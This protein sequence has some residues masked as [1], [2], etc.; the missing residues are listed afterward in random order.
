MS[1]QS[2]HTLDKDDLAWVERWWRAT[3]YVAAAQIFLKDNVLLREPLEA[4]HIKPRL[5]GH[6]G[7]SPG[8]NLLYTHLLRAAREH[9]LH[10][11]FVAGPGHGAPAVLA[12]VWLEGS[13]AEVEPSLER[14]ALGLHRLCRQFSTPGGVSSHVGPHM[15]GSLHEGGELG[16]GLLHAFGAVFDHPELLALAVVGDGEAETG[17]ASGAWKS[18]HYLNPGRDGAVLPVLHLNGWRIAAPT[19][20]G[21]MDDAALV[22]HFEG[23]GYRVLVVAGEEPQ[24]VHQALAS[25]M[26]S[27]MADIKAIQARW[28]GQQ[29]AHECTP[30]WPM[31][32][33]RTPKGWTGPKQVDGHPVE[34]SFRSHQVPLTRAR[35]D[36]KQ[37]QQLA[38]WLTSYR[39]KELFD[40]HGRPRPELLQG[41]P[42]ASYLPGR[43]AAANGGRRRVDLNLPALD[44]AAVRVDGPGQVDAES[45]RALGVWL[46]ELLV[47]NARHHNVRM[48]CPD[49]WASNRLDAV[50]EVTARCTMQPIRASDEA[51]SQDGRVMEVLSEHCCEGWLEGYTLTGRYGL[52]ACYEAFAPIVDSMINQHVKWLK[53]ASEV[54]WRRPVP[55]LNILLTSHTWR[56]DHNGYSHQGPGF[57]DNVLNR[58]HRHVR[59]YLAPDANCLLSV[60]R[61]TFASSDRINLIIAGKQPMP[62]WLPIEQ[63][64]A[65]CAAGASRWHFAEGGNAE[66]PEVVLACAGD[67]P[68]LEVMAAADLLRRHVPGFSFRVVNVVNLLALAHPLDH[69]DGLAEAEYEALFGQREPV[70][71]AFHG[72]PHVIDGL[73]QTRGHGARF[74]SEGYRE[75]GTTTT[76]FDMVVRNRVSRYHLARQALDLAGR[77]DAPAQALREHCEHLLATHE[78]YIREHLEDMPAVTEWRWPRHTT[79]DGAG[80]V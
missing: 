43:C 54:A 34:G 50:F 35:S 31:I 75:E 5:L 20:F 11:L 42:G 53:A 74:H 28:R 7:T 58:K 78:A 25:A 65:H 36:E 38:E 14:S 66:Y 52:F 71:F 68:T 39:P 19:V 46:R 48:F 22:K 59:V 79:A 61:H 55:G 4:E 3:N 69:P 73:A 29:D 40:E 64:D 33:L 76:P 60:A 57:I 37:R 13:Y 41:L 16:Y 67:L 63:A 8:L 70:L 27:A 26:D 12:N 21:R 24:A 23:L 9:Q 51:L 18:I 32:I 2:H 80:H 77:D 17:P 30:G 15:P 6:W 1:S 72:Y 49:E 47:A 62:Q 44:T 10:P 45:T 56:Q